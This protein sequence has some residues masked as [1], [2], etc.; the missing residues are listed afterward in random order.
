MPVKLRITDGYYQIEP[1]PLV[2]GAFQIKLYKDYLTH[3]IAINLTLNEANKWMRKLRTK[4]SN[5]S[6]IVE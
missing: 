1:Y 3:V 5:S 6:L 2:N 4:H